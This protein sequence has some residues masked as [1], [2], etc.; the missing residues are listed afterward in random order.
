LCP[1]TKLEDFSEMV[2]LNITEAQC[3]KLS[4]KYPGYSS[5]KVTLTESS[6]GKAKNWK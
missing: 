3:E 1:E 6:F 4:T 5:F 2:K